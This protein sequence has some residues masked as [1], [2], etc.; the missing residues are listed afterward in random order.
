MVRGKTKGVRMRK[1]LNIIDISAITE[2]FEHYWNEEGKEQLDIIIK[3]ECIYD[4]HSIEHLKR[5]MEI[6]WLNGAYIQA[7]ELKTK[8]C[9]N[10]INNS[11]CGVYSFLKNVRN[12]DEEINSFYC[13]QHS[14]FKD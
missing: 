6:C 5:I 2:T 9:K 10:C 8:S 11:F 3:K 13:N 4:T 14:I 12:E 7:E 1:C